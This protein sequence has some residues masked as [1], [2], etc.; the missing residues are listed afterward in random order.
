MPQIIVLI[1]SLFFNT[2]H[3][4][5][6][7]DPYIER[8][9]ENLNAI[10]IRYIYSDGKI[11]TADDVQ[12]P[13]I[14]IYGRQEA[15]EALE[16]IYEN[17]ILTLQYD[18]AVENDNNLKVY[19]ELRIPNTTDLNMSV[20]DGD[21]SMDK[22]LGDISLQSYG[23]G[24][25]IFDEIIADEVTLTLNGSGNVDIHKGEIGLLNAKLVGSGRI[26]Y[27]GQADSAVF[28]IIGSGQI[29]VHQVLTEIINQ[30][31]FGSGRVKIR[32]Y[33]VPPNKRNKS[34]EDQLQQESDSLEQNINASK[35]ETLER[36]T[37]IIAHQQ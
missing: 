9:F 18:S 5:E 3:A 12:N 33:P 25:F 19:V 17:N 28:E 22:L 29:N 1:F 13:S 21:W 35:Q 11:V 30:A 7:K 8:I 2:A 14:K 24:F 15:L 26:S 27:S 6:V 32:N 23:D 16:I 10:D 34:L 4:F 36:D 20:I 37:E 31:V